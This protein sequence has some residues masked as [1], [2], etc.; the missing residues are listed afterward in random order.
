MHGWLSVYGHSHS[1]CFADMWEQV[2]FIETI[3][4]IKFVYLFYVYGEPFFIIIILIRS[5]ILLC[6]HMHKGGGERFVIIRVAYLLTRP[7]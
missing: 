6:T 7:E 5:R 2:L 3:T 1:V 4:L